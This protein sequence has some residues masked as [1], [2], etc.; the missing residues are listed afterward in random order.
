MEVQGATF[1]FAAL[2][3]G[4][5]V[6]QTVTAQPFSSSPIR[7]TGLASEMTEQAL[8]VHGVFV[9]IGRDVGYYYDYD[10]DGIDDYYYYDTE[11]LTEGVTGVDGNYDIG[12][13]PDSIAVGDV[14]R[15]YPYHS[16]Q[17]NGG[18][19]VPLI[20][21]VDEYTGNAVYGNEVSVTITDAITYNSDIDVLKLNTLVQ[22]FAYGFDG[23]PLSGYIS[24]SYTHLT[25]PTKRIV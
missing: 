6:T 10:G 20:D 8:P 15:L 11:D 22:V 2:D 3:A 16:D 19:L 12:V 13:S 14:V 9:E 5:T 7:F 25:L 24:V 17:D 18:R 21:V 23:Q 4:L 1:F